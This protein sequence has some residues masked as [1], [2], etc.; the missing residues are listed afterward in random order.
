MPPQLAS[1]VGFAVRG[2]PVEML[3]YHFMAIKSLENIRAKGLMRGEVTVSPSDR[4][5]N[6]RLR[7]HDAMGVDDVDEQQTF[8]ARSALA[9][10]VVQVL[11]PRAQMRMADTLSIH[12]SSILVNRAQEF[13]GEA[14]CGV[15]I[16][17]RFCNHDAAE[18]FDQ[19]DRTVPTAADAARV[20]RSSLSAT[21]ALYITSD[22]T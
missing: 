15:S 12:A 21:T 17:R 13:A 14:A 22:L 8:H 20:A 10:L 4:R 2:D 16:H 18:L 3:L 19:R 9:G 11:H 5:E 1:G 7:Y 6:V